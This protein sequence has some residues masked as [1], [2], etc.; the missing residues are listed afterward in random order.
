M[1]EGG[2]ATENI[3]SRFLNHNVMLSFEL[4][5]RSYV[6][7]LRDSYCR[8]YNTKVFYRL[9]TALTHKLLTYK[10]YDILYSFDEA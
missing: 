6:R 3:E 9:L 2:K 10:Y 5:P 8:Y 7:S 4:Q 1:G